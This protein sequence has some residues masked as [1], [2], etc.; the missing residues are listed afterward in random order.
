MT[1]LVAV[2]SWS[3]YTV[4]GR[5]M[6]RK[7]GAYFVNARALTYGA[8]MFFPIGLYETIDFDFGSAPM[9]AYAGVLYM[10][11]MTSMVAYTIWLWALKHME[12]SKV[13]VVNNLQPVATAIM[14]LFLFGEMFTTL[15]IA[16]GF[17]VLFGV[18]LTQRG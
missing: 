5:P 1:I 15:F 12:T 18:Y 17:I 9:G 2:I 14:S 7:Y 4:L 10:A 8:I 13:G 6:I 11:I 16:G 3:F